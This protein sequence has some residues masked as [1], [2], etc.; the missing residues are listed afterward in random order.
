MQVKLGK[1]DENVQGIAAGMSQLV[2]HLTKLQNFPS[3]STSP[4]S[5]STRS[6]STDRNTS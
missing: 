2:Q 3:V 6:Y 4:V 1:L 5:N